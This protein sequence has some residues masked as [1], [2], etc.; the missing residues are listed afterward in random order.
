ME[1]HSPCRYFEH[2]PP[3][4]EVKLLVYETAGQSH[5][6][7]ECGSTAEILMFLGKNL[8]PLI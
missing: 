7:D 8:H 6:G 5:S 4:E 3:S 1:T 2:V